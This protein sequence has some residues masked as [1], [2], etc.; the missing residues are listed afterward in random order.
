MNIVVLGCGPAGLMAA[1]GAMDG[2]ADR[3]MIMSK[4]RKSELFG[5]Q[6]LHEPI[7]GVTE[8]E[9]VH[10]RYNLTGDVE[11]Y[12][13]KVYGRNWVGSVSPE[14]LP[15]DHHAWDIRDT[16]DRLWDFWSPH[17]ASFPDITPNVVGNVVDSADIVINSIPRPAICH[18]GHVFS[19]QQIWA[20]GDAPERGVRL[21]YQCP[22]NTV[23]CN[24]L[25]NPSWYRLSN[26]FDYRTVE[27][28]LET[29][30]KAPPVGKPSLVNKPTRHNCT[31]WHSVHHVG[32]YGRWEKGVL[33]HTAYADAK[34]LVEKAI[35]NG[36]QGELL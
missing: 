9:P 12:R 7:P 21:P 33:S 20:A 4:K 14:D 5:A 16:Y 13:E 17:I 22:P 11:E 6:Y 32:R 29:M 30:P 24:G 2:G 31:C 10:V 25:E 1:Q 34:V 18:Q 26:I 27:W 3:I 8:G 23:L 36:I 28:S 19:A 15:P 35:H